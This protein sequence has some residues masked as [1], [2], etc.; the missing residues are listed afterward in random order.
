MGLID[1]VFASR[2]VLWIPV[3]AFCALGYSRASG[4]SIGS[5]RGD[6][7]SMG[8]ILCFSCAVGAVYV[9]NQIADRRVDRENGG[10][11]VLLAGDISNRRG[12]WFSLVLTA[13][14]TV[15]PFVFG[16]PAVSVLSLAA[17]CLGILYSFKPFYLSGRPVG[18]FVTNA[19]GY[20]IIAFGVGWI[21]AGGT[22]SALVFFRAAAPYFFL[23]CGGSIGSTL[24]DVPGDRAGNKRTTAVAFGLRPAAGL[25]LGCL[26][27]GAVLG[28]VN[29]DFVAQLSGY[30][31]ASISLAY[32]LWPIGLLMESTYKVGGAILVFCALPVLPVFVPI[33]AG[34]VLATWVY[35][36]FRHGVQY[37]SLRPASVK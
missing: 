10:C 9:L 8:L 31:G 4:S 1:L 2:P 25:A 16:T 3:W 36:R 27:V 6:F 14:A 11:P 13:I 28:T 20:G 32:F 17:V 21:L 34:V 15:I 26:L 35:F 37:P 7:A 12:V 23:M 24:P 30:A 19:T 29:N 33:S 5:L 18:D 22:V